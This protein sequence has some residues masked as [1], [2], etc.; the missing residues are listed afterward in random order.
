[1]E[2]GLLPL[3]QQSGE[4][5]DLVCYH[6][7]GFADEENPE[8]CRRL[9]EDI[10]DKWLMIMHNHGLLSVGRTVAEAFFYLYTLENA[11]KVQ[12]DVMASGATP[13]LMPAEPLKQLSDYSRP[14]ATGPNDASTR[15][16][17]ALIRMLDQQEPS[18]KT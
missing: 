14:S 6:D 8:E 15:S 18:Y 11:C 17:P 7:Y 1:M 9:G 4:I 12:V 10:A 2:E 16:W 13:K 5:F 3:S